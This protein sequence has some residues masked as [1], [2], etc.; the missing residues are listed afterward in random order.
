MCLTPLGVF[1]AEN[2]PLP[3]PCVS[4]AQRFWFVC[5]SWFLQGIVIW[6]VPRIYRAE[7]TSILKPCVYARKTLQPVANT[8][9]LHSIGCGL[10]PASGIRTS[11]TA[12]SSRPPGLC[13]MEEHSGFLVSVVKRLWTVS[14]FHRCL[15]I[16]QLDGS[17][18]LQNIGYGVFMV[19]L[20]AG[21]NKIQCLTRG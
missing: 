3:G 14:L 6:I 2:N 7:G 16:R 8:C 13:R 17:W 5:N 1:R 4:E 15:A 11:E 9:I 18:C 19:Q 12:V 20:S 10:S 21:Q